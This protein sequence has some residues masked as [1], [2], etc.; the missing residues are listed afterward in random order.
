MHPDAIG[1]FG[2]DRDG[3]NTSEC[4][5]PSRVVKGRS[6]CEKT[7]EDRQE[8]CEDAMIA[9]FVVEQ[10]VEQSFSMPR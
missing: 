4:F 3:S 8:D 1:A 7:Y 6:R 2:C 10:L 9:H 5:G